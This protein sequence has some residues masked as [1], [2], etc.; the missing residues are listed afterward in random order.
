[1]STNAYPILVNEKERL[2]ALQSYHILDT[3]EEKDFDDLAI[4][5]SAICQTP[6]ALVS[7]VDDD[8]QWF[9]AH[10][11]VEV[12]ETP[13]EYSFCAHAIAEPD[14]VMMVPNLSLDVR[15]AENPLVTGET[16]VIF[17]AGVPLVNNEGYAL[18]TL[19]VVDHIPRELNAE[20]LN[21]LRVIA[22]QVMDKLEL[23]KKVRELKIANR[24]LEQSFAYLQT[25]HTNLQKSEVKFR[26]LVQQAPVAIAILRGPELLLESANDQIL[27]V[28]GKDRMILNK[29]LTSALPELE[30]QTFLEILMEVYN[31]GKPFYGLEEKVV[32]VYNQMLKDVYFDFVY[33]PLKDED[34]NTDAIMVVAT[35]VT[36][37]VRARKIV[38]ESNTRLNLALDAGKLGSYDA[39]LKTG[40]TVCT[41]QCKI[42][43]GLEKD[44]VFNFH[45]LMDVV[46][47]EYREYVKEQ[48]NNAIENDTVYQAEYKI[49]WPDGSVH[50]ISAAGKP[51]YDDAGNAVNVVGVTQNITERKE[52]EQRKDD[53]LGIVSHELKTPITSLK[54]NLQLLDRHKSDPGNPIFPRLIESSSRSVEKI[55][56]MVDELLNMHRFNEG[57]LKLN[58]SH[59][60]VWEMLNLCCNHVRMSGKHDLILEGD[61]TLQIFA[62]EH[63]ID[64]VVVNFVN[65]AVKYAPESRNIY[66]RVEEE[67]GFV[68]ISV[69][70]EGLGIAAEHLP[71]LFDRYWRADHSGNYYTGLGL[72]LY[73]CAE[74][75]KRHDGAIG[76]VSEPGK[77]STFWFTIPR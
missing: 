34:G 6:V 14:K 11:G 33:Q 71:H 42:N 2:A 69:R 59:F 73:I 1:M 31:T 28:W 76:A 74:I 20:Q 70:D 63:C 45:D 3:V 35:E 56:N 24:D 52:Y 41:P 29:P 61:K 60:T 32:L 10:P 25:L 46:L 75:I 51:Q 18:G 54:G 62:D 68:K 36:E 9:K 15:F 72:G 5:A 65:N 27:K 49:K 50:W 48:L 64:Q 53:F 23:R 17:Y 7:L 26:S 19:C 13:R 30:G 4:L 67:A 43:F 8:R 57:Q 38:I 47:P 66:L 37:E 55:T 16:N 40:V 39:D 58:K 22:R 77:G 21:S 44:S 12:T